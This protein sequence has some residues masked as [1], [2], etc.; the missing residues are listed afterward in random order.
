MANS[1][2]V[3]LCLVSSSSAEPAE[4]FRLTCLERARKLREIAA[5]IPDEEYRE[6]LIHSARHYEQMANA[7]ARR[8]MRG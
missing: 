4:T 5:S 8:R 6:F 3:N 1:S 2:P 7:P